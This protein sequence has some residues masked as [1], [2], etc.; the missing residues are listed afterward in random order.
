[1]KP[2]IQC[3]WLRTHKS[4]QFRCPHRADFQ[5]PTYARNGMIAMWRLCET[6]RTLA[7]RD[8]TP[9]CLGFGLAPTKWVKLKASMN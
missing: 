6:H 3:D 2:E 9:I 4:R 7:M 5:T 8:L 1:M